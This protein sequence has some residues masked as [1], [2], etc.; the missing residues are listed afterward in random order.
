MVRLSYYQF[1]GLQLG[2]FCS[3]PSIILGFFSTR[4]PLHSGQNTRRS[5]TTRAEIDIDNVLAETEDAL[6]QAALLLSSSSIQE[7]RT[8]LRKM[9]RELQSKKLSHQEEQ[10]LVASAIVYTINQVSNQVLS[11]IE[12][13]KEQVESAEGDLTKIPGKMI[14]NLG[15]QADN[16]LKEFRISQ[17]RFVE[18]LKT[19]KAFDNFV[20]FLGSKEVKEASGKALD[21]SGMALLK[22]KAGLESDEFQS[23]QK[24]TI[25]SIQEGLESEELRQFQSKASAAIQDSLSP[26]EK[27]KN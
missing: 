6:N 4:I 8:D 23:L 15:E 22:L 7:E 9:H 14:T 2:F 13:T 24:K 10:D 16:N 12:F 21:F 19:G 26:T 11:A 17:D 27:E 1:L 3:L 5:S 25:Q 20:T 18:D